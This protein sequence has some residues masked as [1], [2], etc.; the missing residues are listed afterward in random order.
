[1]VKKFGAVRLLEFSVFMMATR[2]LLAGSG[3]LP[4]MLASQLLQSVTYMTT[5]YSCVVF[6]SENVQEGKISQG[7]S[8]LAMVQAGI[9]AVVGSILGGCMTE[10]LGVSL[11]FAVLAAGMVAV[12]LV[13]ILII[14]YINKKRKKGGVIHEI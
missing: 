3:V 4:L 1:M 9:G 7:Q 6:I 10:R 8:R 2:L 5:Y 14:Y 12:G 13:N 11:S